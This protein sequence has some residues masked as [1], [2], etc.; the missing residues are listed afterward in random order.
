MPFRTRPE[1]DELL[2]WCVSGGHAAVRLVTGD[3]GAGKTRLAL[4][5]VDEVA[6]N[7]WQPL[8]VRRGLER[9]AVR[10]VHVLGQPCVL[11]VDYAETRS[12]LVGL[13]DDVS[14][15]RDGPD[16]RV[17]LLA[18][19]AGEWWQRLLANAE[20]QTAA[21]LEASTLVA[22]GPVRAAG[23]PQEVFDDAVTAFVQ[24][25]GTGRPDVRLA[26]SDPDPVVLV[27]HAAALLAAVDYATGTSPRNQA[28]SGQE[29]LEALLGHEARYWAHSAA[30][31]GLDLDLSVLRLA[32]A[33]GCLIGAESE[34]AAGALLSRVPDLGS[35]ERRGRVARWLHDLYPAVLHPA[36]PDDDAQQEWIGPL[37]PDRLAEQLVTSELT[38]RPELIARLFTGLGEVRAARALTVLARA[39]QTQHHA[40]G[41]LGGALTAD[42]DHLAV[43]A[44][45]VAVETNPIVGDL[46]TQAIRRQA[47]SRDT[48]L[49]IAAASPHPSFA[50]AAPNAVVLQRLAED[51]ASDSD[52][53]WRLLDLSNRL[54]E[55]GRREEALAT[56]ERATIIFRR[57]AR[58]RPDIF[59]PGLATSLSNQSNRLRELGRHEEALAAV[60]QATIIHRQ[61]VRTH[62]AFLPGLAM[63]LT[64][65]S[66]CVANLGGREEALAAIQQATNI[67]RQLARKRGEFL[68]QLATSLNN[69]S[70]CLANLGRPEEALAA[71]EEAVTIYW[72]LADARPDALL[73]SLAG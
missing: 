31:R 19:S 50:L 28:A 30:S 64:N 70:K 42:L 22:L 33:A 71:A 10:A 47:I 40:V 69:Q 23:G 34:T 46:L 68:P 56:I 24:K 14:A 2:D 61:L 43:P 38:R 55:L 26:L 16:L 12:E 29:V 32:V 54:A 36:G 6:I 45:S 4:R 7:G 60:E 37:R 72:D 67:Y 44:L 21:L 27:V 1:L 62:D 13:L 65:Q 41:L 20:E 52:R 57:L 9:D 63:S 3:G 11:M 49:R 59:R 35:A 58:G 51:S 18:R 73:P 15:D 53:V 25:L 5:L 66:L 48:L 17:L 8:W 39:A